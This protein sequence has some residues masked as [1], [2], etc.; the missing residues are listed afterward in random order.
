MKRALAS[1][2]LFQARAPIRL[3]LLAL[4][5]TFMLA[6]CGSQD[7]RATDSSHQII[8]FKVPDIA[9]KLDQ[10]TG[11]LTATIAVNGGTP[12]NMTV[13]DTDATATVSNIPLGDTEFQIVFTYNLD[14]FG[15]LVVA[16]ATKTIN[17][18]AGNNTLTFANGDYD[19]ASF[20]EDGDGL[21]N[22]AELD[23]SSTTD[24]SIADAPCILG[25]SLIGSCVLGS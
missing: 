3:Y 1:Y 14:P 22:L 7:E 20:D 12:Q 15:P 10:T 17:V 18:T 19:T 13:S 11:I 9:S 2:K 5:A 6:G 21:S 16:S 24:P 4:I 25:T 23:E 8:S